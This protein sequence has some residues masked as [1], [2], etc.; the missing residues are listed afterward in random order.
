MNLG[1][2]MLVSYIPFFWGMWCMYKDE[3]K[4]HEDAKPIGRIKVGK[5][6]AL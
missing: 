4:A 5:D 2:V 3:E 1:I 6:D